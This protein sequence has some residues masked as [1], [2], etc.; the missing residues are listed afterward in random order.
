MYRKVRLVPVDLKPPGVKVLPITE[1]EAILRAADEV[2]ATGGRTM[3]VKILKGSRVKRLLELGYDRCPVYGF[4]RAMKEEEILARVD[5]VIIH[6]FLEIE[7]N[8]RLPLLVYTV[9]GW[10][11]EKVTRARELFGDLDTLSSQPPPWNLEP[12]KSKHR[13]VVMMLF[14]MVGMTGDA[15]YIPVLHAWREI[16]VK[17]VRARITRL[18]DHL[19]RSLDDRREE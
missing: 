6:G 14:D 11:I 9:R 16:E 17:K 13:E 12:F 7:Y 2:V 19:S 3:L 10:E 18:I 5:W 15:R 1:I 8:Y 4:Y